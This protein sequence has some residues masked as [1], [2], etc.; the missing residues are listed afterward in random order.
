MNIDR[1]DWSISSEYYPYMLG[2]LVYYNGTFMSNVDNNTVSPDDA[3]NGY[4]FDYPKCYWTHITNS[5]IQNLQ[6]NGIGKGKWSTESISYPY[7]ID[8]IIF[9]ENGGLYASF[10]SLV[11][12]NITPPD[13]I[14][15]GYNGSDIY[16]WK[17]LYIFNI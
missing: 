5:N 7:S 8:D 12:D 17:L 16:H 14:V 13:N 4:L 10:I 1:G 11:N 2:D 6:I 15:N 3:I 9:Y